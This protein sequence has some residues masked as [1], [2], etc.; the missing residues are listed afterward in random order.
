MIF[1]PTEL[2][3]AEERLRR[4]VREF[5]AAELPPDFR[6][7]LGLG[8]RHDPEFSRKLA[9]HGWV[10]MAIPTE[11][12]GGGAT[13]VERFVVVEELLAAGAPILAHWVAERQTAPTLLAFG[14]QEQREWFLPRIAAGEC[15]FSLGMS[16]P[17]A[18]S[19]LASVRTAATKVDG[20]WL[21]NGTKIWTSAAHL[22]HFFVV[23][24]RTSPAED[25]HHG[26]SQLIVDLHAPGLKVSPI[27]YLDGGHHFNEVVF[28]DVFVPDDRVLGEVGAGWHQVTSEL[29]YERSGPD[30][31]LSVFGLLKAFVT[32]FGESFDD[33]QRAAVGRASAKL[34]TIRQ[35][36][37]AVARSLERGAAPAVE[38]A[39]VKDIGTL[40]EQ[41]VVEV[42]RH[43]AGQEIDPGGARM[44]ERLLA[45]AVQTAPAF[46]LRGGTTEV[47]RSIAA[48]GLTGAR[49]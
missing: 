6:P 48:K 31:Y 41:E 13:P 16:E 27:H 32:E 26:L 35:L 3:P 7:G 34:W 14:T 9:A 33:A 11:Y 28:D 25:R 20:G 21:V 17:D 44:F 12:G 29:A 43:V 42:L 22:N 45:E 30:R 15:W 23:L 5:L 46:T 24:C 39:L 10:G 47:L 49:R 38:A 4:D 37:L 40:Y 1:A 8:G 18:G 36:S 2:T 19:D